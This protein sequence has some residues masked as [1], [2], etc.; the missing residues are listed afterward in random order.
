MRQVSELFWQV[1]HRAE[2]TGKCEQFVP[3]N[4]PG[5]ANLDWANATNM[6]NWQRDKNY[7]EFAWCEDCFWVYKAQIEPCNLAD[8][9][10]RLLTGK[11]I[12]YEYEIYFNG[13][14]IY[15]YEGM[16][17]P[18]SLDIGSDS[19][20]I[21][22]IIF[23]IPKDK[24][25]TKG[26]RQ[27]AAQSCKPAV[28]YE[29]DWHPRLV[30]VGI[31]DE[32]IVEILPKY[33]LKSAEI[34]YE[35][36]NDLSL[37]SVKLNTCA[38][39][40]ILF[41]LYAP[42]G[43][44][45]F[46][47][48]ACHTHNLQNPL[49]WWCNGYGTPNLYTWRADCVH[50]GKICDSKTGKIGFRKIELTMNDGTWSEPCEFPKGRSAVPIT[51]T[52]NN[53]AVF[54]KGSN[55]VNPEVFSGTIT[56]DTYEPLVL[57]GKQANFNIFRSW[58]G[59]IINKD[60]FFE[61]C[62]EHG[63]MVW[64][65]FMLACN[66]YRNSDKYLSVLEKEAT[67]IIHRLKK[68]ASVVI[69]CGGN[70]LFNNWS[71]MTDQSYALRLL[72]KLCYEHDYQ[73]RPFL[74]T[75]PLYGMAHGCYLFTYPDGR[76][77]FEVMPF[78]KHTAYTEFGVP[79]VSNYDC[80]LAATDEKNVFPLV[81]NDI[82]IAHHAFDAWSAP[83]YAWCELDTLR[84]YFGEPTDIHDMIEK[85]Q[86]LQGEGYKCI[87]EEARRQK[88]YCSMAINWCYSEPW[89]TIA[90]N[91]I[92]NYPHSPKA[93]FKDVAAACR[94]VLAS[95]QI[96]HFSF[97]QGE[98]F[99]AAL[100]MLNDGTKDIKGGKVEVTLELLGKTYNLLNW[101]YEPLG[102]NKN[103][104][105]PVVRFELPKVEI[106]NKTITALGMNEQ[107]QPHKS[108]APMVLRLNAGEY[109]STYKLVYKY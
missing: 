1:G 105:G 65:E 3:A 103:L 76:E 31:W 89:P 16:F 96:P 100:W 104:I 91:S 102:A 72:N 82:T 10:V 2:K 79:S 32:L 55:W 49:L 50:N 12:D 6:P 18:F 15:A 30:P 7:T 27:E 99:E 90:N 28:S 21:E 5:N 66:D 84:K 4:V 20:E 23:P 33:N 73:K 47:N 48:S 38:N 68:Y 11:G 57:L 77:V 87:Y 40:N 39:A 63:I 83:S 9:E 92:I 59:G 58:G 81:S 108:Y 69:W 97:A 64:Q 94:N 107:T 93:S 75:S 19:G 67:A 53:V 61:L 35:L 52:L 70:E 51:I 98:V 46:E 22:I 95:A 62:D 109:S 85:S 71:C 54:A 8:G 74:A 43:E 42:N 36:S 44:N 56:K 13:N 45:I 88:P 34:T 41:S 29:W 80:L 106:A 78:A 86:W 60:S 17:A 37:A 14:L 101:E 26:T 24:L 25:G